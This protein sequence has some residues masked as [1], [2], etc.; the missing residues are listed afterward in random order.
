QLGQVRELDVLGVIV[1]ELS[2]QPHYASAALTELGG[3]IDEE[4]AQ[5]RKRLGARLSSHKLARLARDLK[6]AIERSGASTNR[7]RASVESTHGPGW[8]L[9]ARL[10]RRAGQLRLAVERAG[11]L[12]LP[13]RLHDV[14]I[15][16][17]KLRYAV[18]LWAAVGAADLKADLATLKLT[19]D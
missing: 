10:A 13:E 5:A 17:K 1:R 8:A 14:R 2:D 19:Q 7:S 16:V 4:A 15:A 11:V 9:E 6:R 18:E 3:A 12:Y